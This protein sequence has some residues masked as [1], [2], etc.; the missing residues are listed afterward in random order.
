MS[1]L[2]LRIFD[3]TRQLFSAPAQFLVTITDGNRTQHIRQYFSNNDITFELPFFDNLGDDYSVLAWA[4]GHKQA[5][6]VPVALSDQYVKTLDIMLVPDHPGFSFVNA[7]WDAAK[8]HYPF[9]G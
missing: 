8:A 4:Q 6:F 1:K 5:G 2:Q 7:R 3:G 9:L